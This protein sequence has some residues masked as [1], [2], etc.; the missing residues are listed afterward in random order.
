MSIQETTEEI[1]PP[2]HT[3]LELFSPYHTILTKH[4]GE[5]VSRSNQFKSNSNK[6]TF[7]VLKNEMLLHVC[8][9][10]YLLL[11]LYVLD[12]LYQCSRFCG[13]PQM[14]PLPCLRGPVWMDMIWIWY[15]YD[16][17]NEIQKLIWINIYTNTTSINYYIKIQRSVLFQY[18]HVQDVLFLLAL[19][20]YFPEILKRLSQ[21]KCVIYFSDEVFWDHTIILASINKKEIFLQDF[22]VIW[23]RN[24][25]KILKNE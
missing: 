17:D 20:N 6:E 2:Y 12:V 25:S 10:I 4:T 5:N 15:G 13:G 21:K 11:F 19:R 14:A 16:M 24:S 3:I 9:A 18:D 22:L 7:L 23:K 8:I 1:F